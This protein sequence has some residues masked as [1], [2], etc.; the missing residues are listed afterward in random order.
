MAQ[1]MRP[2]MFACLFVG[3]FMLASSTS[4][5][6]VDT[7]EVQLTLD[8]KGETTDSIKRKT[9]GHI[10][11]VNESVLIRGRRGLLDL[12]TEPDLWD[13]ALFKAT[14]ETL[15]KTGVEIAETA[16]YERGVFQS[17]AAKPIYSSTRSIFGDSH[18]D[19]KTTLTTFEVLRAIQTRLLSQTKRCWTPPFEALTLNSTKPRVNVG[20]IGHVSHG[21]TTLT[22]AI[23]KVITDL[24]MPNSISFGAIQKAP[25]EKARGITINT[26]HVEYETESRHYVHVDCPIHADYV[27]NMLIGAARMDG[28]IL[29]VDATTGPNSR[30]DEELRIARAA[31]VPSVLAFMNKVDL[32]DDEELLELVE[33]E[34]RD[35]L[36]KYD[37]PGDETPVIRGSALKAAQGDEDWTPAIAELLEA[38][39]MVIPLPEREVD[40][41]FLMPVEDVFSV[42]GGG[43]TVTGRVERGTLLPDDEIEIVGL[44][45]T[46]KTVVTGVEMFRK[47][48]D[49]GQAGDNIGVLLRGVGRE[50]AERGQ[51]LA[52]PGFI[53]PHTKFNAEVYILQKEE[54]G[55]H[56]PF[57]KGYRPQ[58]Y[59]RTTDV[60]GSVELPEGVEMVMPGDNINIDVTLDESIALEEGLRFAIREGGR[61]VGAGRLLA[62]DSDKVIK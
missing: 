16:Q 42:T 22:A 45:E 1:S 32:V 41:S 53:T 33:M 35:L 46:Q 17:H 31:G 51:V 10:A 43:T 62:L 14:K 5:T 47:S 8:I 27:K 23:R 59:F 49:E 20:L 37:F 28:A 60:T 11:S 25:E 50:D 52:K 61:T 18:E 58:F 2:L 54:G 29:V 44:K 55:R 26:S 4:L 39:D 30:D 40:K 48:L 34:V 6:A 56:T 36:S 19:L 3:I 7:Q 12:L 24:V 13:D 57:F 38:M 21:K 9:G 15:S